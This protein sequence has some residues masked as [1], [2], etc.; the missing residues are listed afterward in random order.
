MNN[1]SNTLE[2]K[3]ALAYI[4]ISSDRQIN[5]ES[6]E[7]QK[8]SIENYA[9]NNSIQ[10]VK[11]FFDEAVSGKNT[12]RPELKNMIDYA[13]RHK[14]EID[15]V[16]VYKMSRA[17]RDMASY[18][19]GFMLP[20]KALGISVRSATEQ[21]DDSATG[22]FM[23]GINILVAQLD[24]H[25][26]RDF[27]IDNMTSLSLQGW[28][29]GPAPLGYDN[30]RIPNGLGKMRPSLKKN[31]M[32]EYVKQTLERFSKGD[33]TKAEL[34]RYATK[35][36]LR[37]RYGKRLSEDSI[38][39]LIKNPI[40]AGYISNKQ[41]QRELVSGM[42][43]AIISRDTYNINQ[44]LIYGKRSKRGEIR[45]MINP[46]YPLKGLLK[47]PNCAKSMYASAPKTGAGGKS[48]RYHCSRKSCVGLN[49]SIKASEIHERFEELLTRIVPDEKIIILY[50]E[51]LIVEAT[52]QLGNINTKI[53]NIR[54][55]LDLVAD[56]RLN[57]IRNF[58]IG[59]L[60]LEEKNDLV[61][62]YDNDKAIFEDELSSLQSLQSIKEADIDLAI[63][64]MRSIDKQWLVAP[65][66]VQQR[67]QSLL[68]PK[69][70]VY[71]YERQR[72][73]TTEISHF[74]RV[75]TNKK[76]SEMPSKSFLVAGVGFEPTTLWL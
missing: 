10:I 26:K 50:R 49:K 65:I 51:V 21:I 75:N 72:F 73:G 5:G 62:D 9:K 17:S 24:N 25:N 46:D 37:S 64:I 76:D 19:T 47:C 56:N 58:N 38:N 53:K 45:Q 33:I 40:Y 14:H 12:E 7:T 41:T 54:N 2:S 28:W 30:F 6:P 29:Q 48:P 71:D 39:R 35:I 27:T 69:G 42:H 15:H 16:I 74:Y 31:N 1:N 57:A 36:G 44:T 70:L 67:F 34:T 55:R 68:F 22:Q 43:E 13:K 52:S 59:Q 23:E 3:K 8:H 18:F 63:G 20:L 32:A 4:R 61:I 66:G 60:S 11:T